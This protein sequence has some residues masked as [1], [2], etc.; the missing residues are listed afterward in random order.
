LQEGEREG[1][2][3]EVRG[4]WR[5]RD[6]DGIDL[7]EGRRRYNQE[8]DKGRQGGGERKGTRMREKDPPLQLKSIAHTHSP[9]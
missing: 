6:G 7:G 1:V 3:R 2:E 8:G 4:W 5:V 9:V